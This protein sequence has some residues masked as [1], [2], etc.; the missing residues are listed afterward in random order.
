MF[1]SR[2]VCQRLVHVKVPRILSI[3]FCRRL[4][5]L[6]SRIRLSEED[7]E[8]AFLK[9]SGPGGQKINKTAS[10]V[11]LKHRSSGFV[12]KCQATRSRSQNRNIAR[13]LLADKV[14]ES[15]RGE[16]SRVAIKVAIKRKKK[17]SKTKKARRKYKKLES[18]ADVAGS[19]GEEQSSEVDHGVHADLTSANTV[20]P[21]K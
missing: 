12:V 10:A 7:I 17:A 1:L 11:Q 15:Q 16:K 2:W 4:S 3:G 8:E 19:E 6:P 20:E 9:G 21:T 5:Q 13:Q 18:D 14:E